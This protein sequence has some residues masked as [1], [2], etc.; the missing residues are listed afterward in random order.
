MDGIWLE[1][2]KGL[3]MGLPVAVVLAQALKIVW[4]KYQEAL[5]AKD[6]LYREQAAFFQQ[7]LVDE[8]G[9]DS[10]QP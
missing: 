6:A 7:L 1:V 3:G 8:K 9:T 2:A 4:G 5:E 10:G